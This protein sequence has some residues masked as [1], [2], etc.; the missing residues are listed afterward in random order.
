MNSDSINKIIK[1]YSNKFK[2][3]LSN[4]YQIETRISQVGTTYEQI[5]GE[6]ERMLQDVENYSTETLERKAEEV[7][8]YLEFY[9][10][11][12]Q[13][14]IELEEG[15]CKEF[16]HKSFVDHGLK[17]TPTTSLLTYPV[18]TRPPEDPISL[19]FYNHMTS[20][21]F[22][23]G[24]TKSDFP[25]QKMCG[26]CNGMCDLYI[27]KKCE[28]A[29]K[30]DHCSCSEHYP[31]CAMCMIQY[32][33]EKMKSLAF[34]EQLSFN[35]AYNTTLCYLDCMYCQGP[36][37]LYDIKYMPYTHYT[38]DLNAYI[39]ADFSNKKGTEVEC[40]QSPIEGNY[41][42]HTHII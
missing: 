18:Q 36:I 7:S 25:K 1:F 35:E 8:K 30:H 27:E 31:L 4:L 24:R 5:N 9:N 13:T 10:L 26:L 21:M 23:E 17:E 39:S 34:S 41:I 42:I 3:D 32:I 40:K 16:L 20:I 29:K 6:L 33:V 15:V 37:C 14:K 11:L 2:T 38:D 22:T 19:L 28:R 12:Q